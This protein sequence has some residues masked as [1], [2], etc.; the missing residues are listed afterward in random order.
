[1]KNKNSAPF[2]NEDFDDDKSNTLFEDVEVVKELYS[3]FN[4]YK[5]ASF[6]SDGR[7]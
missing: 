7:D 4:N 6:D 5:R 2:D 3:Q 1:M